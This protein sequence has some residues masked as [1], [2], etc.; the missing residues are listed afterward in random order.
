MLWIYNLKLYV[1]LHVYRKKYTKGFLNYFCVINWSF[2]FL[3]VTTR[4]LSYQTCASLFFLTMWIANCGCNYF[5]WYENDE[6]QPE[7]QQ[8][9]ISKCSKHEEKNLKPI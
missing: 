7:I 6:V 9:Q 4:S 5:E 1:K 3:C 8:L 2:K